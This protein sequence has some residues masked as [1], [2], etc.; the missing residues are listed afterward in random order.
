MTSVA[1]LGKADT[2]NSHYAIPF[3]LTTLEAAQRMREALAPNGVVLVNVLSSPVGPAADPGIAAMLA[4]R[5]DLP[6]GAA[7]TVLTDD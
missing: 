2:F 6:A 3:H 4:R 5:F 1:E 7:Q